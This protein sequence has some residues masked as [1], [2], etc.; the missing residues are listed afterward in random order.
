MITKLIK[1]G[2]ALLVLHGAFRVG[3][4]YW[5]F[6]RFEDKLQELAQFGD[7]KSDP[8]ICDAAMAAAGNYQVPITPAQLTVR[9]GSNPP[10]NCQNGPVPIEDGGIP[11]PSAQLTIDGSYMDQLQV[12]PGYY[13]P[14][15]FVPSVKVWVRP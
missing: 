7:Q 12:L 9:R 2:L 15:E 4:A 14:W 3:N 13:Y 11:Q 6:Y 10:Y 8:Q 1:I 5:T